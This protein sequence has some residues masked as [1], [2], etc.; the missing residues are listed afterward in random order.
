MLLNKLNGKQSRPPAHPGLPRLSTRSCQSLGPDPEKRY[1]RPPSSSRL[2][3][4]LPA[5]LRKALY[6]RIPAVKN[7]VKAAVCLDKE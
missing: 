1:T 4:A 6:G 2:D 7:S 5:R 3:A